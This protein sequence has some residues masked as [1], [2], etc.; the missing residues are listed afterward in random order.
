MQTLTP[1]SGRIWEGIG[2]KIYTALAL[3]AVNTPAKFQ[4]SS[5]YSSFWRKFKNRKNF[6]LLQPSSMVGRRAESQHLFCIN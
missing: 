3:A 4:L 2:L 6:S 5:F 1:P